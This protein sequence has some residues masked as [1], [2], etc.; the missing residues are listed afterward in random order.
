MSED[1]RDFIILGL[2]LLFAIIGV[3]STIGFIAR[4]VMH[5]ACF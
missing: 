1:M 4:R 2:W 5:F 3:L